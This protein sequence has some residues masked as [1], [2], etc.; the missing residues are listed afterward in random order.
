M[1]VDIL[2]E[3]GF[4]V[5]CDT[6]QGETLFY[7]TFAKTT[8]REVNNQLRNTDTNDT[9]SVSTATTDK[10][11]VCHNRQSIIQDLVIDRSLSVSLCVY[12]CVC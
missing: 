11:V 7:I 1:A 5:T 4:F 8:L 2:T 10:F 12:V 9:N 6:A 3:R